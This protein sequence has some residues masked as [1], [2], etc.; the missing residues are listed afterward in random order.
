MKRELLIGELVAPGGWADVSPETLEWLGELLADEGVD[1]MHATDAQLERGTPVYVRGD[2]AAVEVQRRMAQRHIRR[3]PVVEDGQL[4]GLID[5]LE[6]AQSHSVT[7]A[8]NGQPTG[9]GG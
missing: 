1:L 7:D 5:L 3:V 8:A 9:G 4:V 6:L 2:A